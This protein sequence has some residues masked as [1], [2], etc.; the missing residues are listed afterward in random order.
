M[1]AAASQRQVFSMWSVPRS[2][3]C[4]SG[5]EC[6]HR[7]PVSHKTQQKGNPVPGVKTEPPCS[8]FQ[9]EGVSNLRQQYVM[10]PA[11]LGP[12]KDQQQDLSSESMLRKDCEHKHSGS[13]FQRTCRQDRLFGGKPPALK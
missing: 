5:F 3:L 4:G 13:E 8:G 9:V 6:L 2:L 10:S 7:S 11:G 12:D 1:Q